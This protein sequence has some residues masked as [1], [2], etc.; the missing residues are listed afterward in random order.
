VDPEASE[1][2]RTVR[3][4][5]WVV[6]VT[7]AIAAVLIAVLVSG[8]A[9]GGTDPEGDVRVVEGERPRRATALPVA[10][11]IADIVDADV[12]SEGSDLILDLTAA[13][14]IPGALERSSL[15]F[16][17]DLSEGGRDTWIVSASINVAATAAVVS[18]TTGYTSS[19]IDDSLPGSLELT[20]ER[21]RITLDPTA[22]D[23][24]PDSFD[25]RLSSA[26]IAFRGIAGSVRVEDR[27]PDEGVRS[28]GP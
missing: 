13:V 15:E 14:T 22:I 9:G 5:F 3:T 4:G 26:L 16:R 7:L 11:S 1:R 10:A 20:G 23:G 28:G 25:W 27:F 24:F 2:P 21:L 12:R 17:F 19:T 8:G 6:G 18:Q